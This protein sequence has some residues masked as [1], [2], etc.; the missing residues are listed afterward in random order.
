MRS[1]LFGR[2]VCLRVKSLVIPTTGAGD[3]SP[4]DRCGPVLIQA[5]EGA[6]PWRRGRRNHR[7]ATKWLTAP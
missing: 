6:V 5:L 3:F 2:R 4:P 1:G 7:A